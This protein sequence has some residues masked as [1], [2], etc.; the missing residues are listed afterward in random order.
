[1]SC[2]IQFYVHALVWGMEEKELD[3][4]CDDV[5]LRT[6]A[7]FPYASSVSYRVRT[8]DLLQ[9]LWYTTKAPRKQ[10]QL[11]RRE[12][13][14]LKQYKRAINGVNSVRLFAAMQGITLEELT[15]AGAPGF[16]CWSERGK[17]Q[18]A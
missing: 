14:S 13:G 9:V 5:R 17:T 11:W 12:K 1:M 6:G 3:A 16:T 4:I 15:L 7:L 18:G 8:G 2:F 10:Y